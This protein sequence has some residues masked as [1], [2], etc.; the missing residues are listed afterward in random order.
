MTIVE[1][2]KTDNSVTLKRLIDGKRYRYIYFDE[3]YG[4]TVNERNG[5]KLT[6]LLETESES[7]A[8]KKLLEGDDVD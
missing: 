8:V 1:A 3:K 7:E 6:F 5:S 2:L 4:W